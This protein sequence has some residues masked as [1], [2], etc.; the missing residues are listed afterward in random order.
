MKSNMLDFF[1]QR[2]YMSMMGRDLV[3]L[4]IK[5]RTCGHDFGGG[6]GRGRRRVNQRRRLP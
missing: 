6:A 3:Y 2:P 1:S 5:G 4:A